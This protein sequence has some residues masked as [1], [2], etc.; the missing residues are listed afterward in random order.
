MTRKLSIKVIC[1]FR[2]DQEYSI[3][4]EEAHKAYYLYL[5]AGKRHV[6]STGLG[7]RS[8][9][10]QRIVPD[11]NG[12]MGWNPG[13]MPTPEDYA[14]IRSEGVQSELQ[15]LMTKA[16]TIARSCGTQVFQLPLSSFSSNQKLLA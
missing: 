2:Q 8:E 11:W 15:G 13:Y 9:D 14:Q 3:P 1:G 12:S 7:L 16:D 4:V 6:F 5:N 10:I